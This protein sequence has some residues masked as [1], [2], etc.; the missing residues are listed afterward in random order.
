MLEIGFNNFVY[1]RRKAYNVDNP[2]QAKRSSGLMNIS[3]SPQP[4][5]GLN[6]YGVLYWDGHS[7]TPSCALL[8]R[9]YPR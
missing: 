5:S 2:L 3:S 9:G 4:R 8:A 1:I 6:S 7:L